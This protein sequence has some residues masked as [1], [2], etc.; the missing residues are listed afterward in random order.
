MRRLA[1]V[2]VIASLAIFPLAC[3]GDDDSG[4]HV[5]SSIV[6]FDSPTNPVI[7]PTPT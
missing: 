4:S 5:D 3:G 7:G 1:L 6:L 2:I